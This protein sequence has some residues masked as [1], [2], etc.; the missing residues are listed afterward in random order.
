MKFTGKR[1][2]P[3]EI[4]LS[5]VIQTQEDK[6]CLY[7]LI[8]GYWLGRKYRHATIHSSRKAIPKRVQRG[9][10]EIYLERRNRK[11]FDGRLEADMDGSMK[12]Q[13]GHQVGRLLKETTGKDI[14]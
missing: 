2:E 14:F 10:I 7:S 3:E 12:D 1:I 6:H 5:D 13:V 8:S 4:I 11:D 9:N